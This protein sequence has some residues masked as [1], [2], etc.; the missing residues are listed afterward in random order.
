MGNWKCHKYLDIKQHALNNQ[1]VKMK[2]KK[3]TSKYLESNEMKQ[4]IQTY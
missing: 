3:I 4:Y 2:L 1:W